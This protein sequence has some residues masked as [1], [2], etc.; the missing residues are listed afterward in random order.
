MV[1]D[2]QENVIQ[3]T[4]RQKEQL[5]YFS[6]SLKQISDELCKKRELN[7]MPGP[8]ALNSIKLPNLNKKTYY[9]SFPERS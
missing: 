5:K 8:I 4:K 6:D 1:R 2:L 7:L 9:D 3:E